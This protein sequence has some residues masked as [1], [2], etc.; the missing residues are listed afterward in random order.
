MALQRLFS[1]GSILIV[2]EPVKFIA[3]TVD[4]SSP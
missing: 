1:P 3:V 4:G 2:R